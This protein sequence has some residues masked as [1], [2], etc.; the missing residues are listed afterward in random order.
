MP[1]KGLIAMAGRI[2][3]P[4]SAGSGAIHTPPVS[5]ER[6][7]GELSIYFRNNVTHGVNHPISAASL[8]IKGTIYRQEQMQRLTVLC[9]VRFT[10]LPPC[11]HQR[12]PSIPDHIMEPFPCLVINGLSNCQ[13]ITHSHGHY[14]QMHRPKPCT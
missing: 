8:R 1:K 4:G 13:Q 12:A 14:R 5:E 6:E 9:R 2:S 11:V 3:A 10:C 7:H